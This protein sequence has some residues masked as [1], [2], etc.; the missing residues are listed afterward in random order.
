M[1]ATVMSALVGEDLS[2]YPTLVRE[3][4]AILPPEPREAGRVTREVIP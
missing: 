4:L 1:P 2:G 3:S